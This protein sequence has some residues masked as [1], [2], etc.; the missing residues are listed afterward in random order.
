MQI[1]RSNPKKIIIRDS[2]IR[3]LW[4]LGCFI[5][6]IIIFHTFM[7]AIDDLIYF[8][9][10]LYLIP[11]SW[12]PEII[13]KIR[14]LLNEDYIQV[15]IERNIIIRQNKELVPITEIDKIQIRSDYW[16]SSEIQNFKLE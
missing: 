11:I 8:K 12:I 3:R 16:I 15:D 6:I 4:G 5:I 9:L 7:G 14:S 1:D 13:D 10:I 2:I